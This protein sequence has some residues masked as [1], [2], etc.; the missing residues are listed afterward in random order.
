M[1]SPVS[2]APVNEPIHEPARP[3][4]HLKINMSGEPGAVEIRPTA[5]ASSASPANAFFSEAGSLGA[6]APARPA[7]PPVPTAHP[8][9]PPAPAPVSTPYTAAP[10]AHPTPTV[11]DVSHTG[12]TASAAAPESGGFVE[13]NPASPVSA[14]SAHYAVNPYERYTV[15]EPYAEKPGRKRKLWPI[16]LILSIVLLLA[17]ASAVIFFVPKVHDAVFGKPEISFKK[18]TIELKVGESY[19]LNKDLEL[20]DVD[21]NKIRW[22]ADD[23]DGVIKLKDGKVEAIGAGSCEIEVYS[24]KDEDVGDS[25]EIIVVAPN[26]AKASDASAEPSDSP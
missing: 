13:T 8:V 4:S 3:A 12:Y 26:E 23:E 14:P 22:E 10:S 5:A 19:D 24:A 25:I 6:E 7:A 20:E 21:E 2:S 18:D 11:S 9:T 15:E 16:I 17:A 1:P